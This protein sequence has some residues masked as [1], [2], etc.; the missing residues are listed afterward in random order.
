MLGFI[1]TK[2]SNFVNLSPPTPGVVKLKKA[3]RA[4]D[5]FMFL[6]FYWS[7]YPWSISYSKYLWVLITT[8]NLQHTRLSFSW[9]HTQI[10]FL[11]HIKVFWPGILSTDAFWQTSTHCIKPLSSP[12]LELWRS[13]VAL[14]LNL[15]TRV[16]I[17]HPFHIMPTKIWPVN[18]WP[19]LWFLKELRLFRI[20][21]E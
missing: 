11:F 7:S 1:I 20:F 8:N 3:F 2:I 16:I 5:F 12:L 6:C 18:Y 9:T 14:N 10:Y 19:E 17:A 13:P 4:S 21:A 15:L